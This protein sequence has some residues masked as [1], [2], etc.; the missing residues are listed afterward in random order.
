V[1][2]NAG[3]STL[4]EAVFFG[5]KIWAIPIKSHFEQ[6]FNAKTLKR[7]GYFTSKSLNGSSFVKWLEHSQPESSRF[8]NSA[9]AICESL[10]RLASEQSP[11]KNVA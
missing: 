11:K 4:S 8:V 9:Y 3:F 2:T 5:K 6:K 7:N 1:I 10:E